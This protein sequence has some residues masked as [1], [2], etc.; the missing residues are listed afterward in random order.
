MRHRCFR[1][2]EYIFI[3]NKEFSR[4]AHQLSS[5]YTESSL[6]GIILDIHFLSLTNYL[7]CGFSSNVRMRYYLHQYTQIYT[8]IHHQ[9]LYLKYLKFFTYKRYKNI[10]PKNALHLQSAEWG[11]LATSR[12]T[13]FSSVSLLP[14]QINF[15]LSFFLYQSFIWKQ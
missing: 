12:S 5:R 11:P 6:R 15:F 4:S 13:Y 8:Y 14:I 10:R 7:V 9:P 1:Y 3:S 2:P